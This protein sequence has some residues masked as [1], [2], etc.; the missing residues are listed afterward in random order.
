MRQDSQ[1]FLFLFSIVLK[2]QP[3]QKE[4]KMKEGMER[5]KI[6]LSLFSDDITVCTG[7]QKNL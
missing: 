6:E 5:K 7:Q 3:A 1:V 2:A 4:K